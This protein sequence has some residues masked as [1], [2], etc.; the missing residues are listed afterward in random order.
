MPRT[1]PVH[2]HHVIILDG[3][4]P[5]SFLGLPSAWLVVVANVI[6]TLLNAGRAHIERTFIEKQVTHHDMAA[7]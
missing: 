5:L 4:A 7:W 1:Q 3:A 2:A 6:V